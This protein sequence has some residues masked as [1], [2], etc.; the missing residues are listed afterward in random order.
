MLR[1]AIKGVWAR[2]L[3]LL[4]T[5]IAVVL[6]VGFVAGAFFLTDSVRSSFDTLFT[7]AAQGLDV[8]VTTKHYTEI[9]QKQASSQPG[10]AAVDLAQI[11]ISRDVVDRVRAVDGVKRANGTVFELGAQPL[12]RKGKP[13]GGQGPPS[14]AAGWIEEPEAATAG[15]LRLTKGSPPGPQDVLLDSKTMSTGRFH[16]GDHVRVLVQGGA[17]QGTYRISGV[18]KFGKQASLVGATITVFQMQTV[19]RLLDMNGRYS[20]IT[21]TADDGVAQA[22]LKTRV[23]TALGSDYAVITGDEFTRQQSRSIDKT[24]LNVVQNVILGFAAI[25]VFVGAFTIFNT[26][27]ILVGQRTREFGLLRALGAGR[28]QI[29]GI[30]VIEAIVLG[31]IASLLGIVAGYGVAWLLRALINSGGE[32]IPKTAFPLRTR[33]LVWAFSVGI[34]VTLVASFLPALRASRLSPL[35]ALRANTP[36][37]R[38]GWKLPALG[39]VLAFAGGVLVA[40]GFANDNGSTSTILAQIGAGFGLFVLGLA[41]LSRSFIA[42]VTRVLSVPFAWG[43]T[44]RLATRNVLRNR[45]RAASTASALMVGLALASLVLV[46]FASLNATVDQQVNDIIGSDISVYNS[47]A[48]GGAMAVVSDATKRRID[49]V[50]GVAS[51]FGQR[52]G[53]AM[54]GT[55]FDAVKG[56][57]RTVVA[58][59]DGALTYG[60]ALKLD[61]VDG[62]VDIGDGGVLVEEKFAA[63]HSWKVGSAAQLAFPTE[64]HRKL[65]VRGIFKA[66]QLIPGAFIVS[67]RTF[68]AVEP[69]QIHASTLVFVAVEQG[70]SPAN[71]VRRITQTL[72]PDASFLTVQDNADLRKQVHD[73]L[74]PVLGLVLGMLSLSLIIALFGIG[75][76]MALNVFERTREIGLLRAVGGTRRQLGRIVRTESILVALF[77][78]VV[79]EV[80]GIG[81]GAAIVTALHDQGFVFAVSAPELIAVLIGGFLA[82]LLASLLP[83]RRAAR[84][85]VLAA[86]ATD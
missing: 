78:A 82:G 51:S 53:G 62:S 77:G 19:Q 33:T 25:A 44:G 48:Q 72:G 8:Q 45:P 1:V 35:E 30:V 42:P 50:D 86:I 39:A 59:D 16:V 28:R 68:D 21:V 56:K 7:E 49:K 4:L 76:T 37:Q 12:D 66:A 43:T 9:E 22:A 34:G 13:I 58:Y 67:K 26:F 2:K 70:Q 18:V 11:G 54:L 31:V 81:A 46:F 79:G 32:V 65:H 40:L 75:N 61:V 85:D 55:R 74:K 14:F 5:S 17:K 29:L 23:Q 24:F 63:K 20:S 64:L 52:T 38:I 83:A 3:R 36:A 71:V 6:G 60:G 57:V 84:T 15:A 10:T 80:V 47:S 27:T 73:Q 41:L 69:V